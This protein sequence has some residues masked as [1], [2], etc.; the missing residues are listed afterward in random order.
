MEAVHTIYGNLNGIVSLETGA[1]GQWVK[2]CQL[3]QP[4]RLTT[5]YGTWI[6]AYTQAT[7]RN[8]YGKSL[9]F[10]PSGTLKA[11]SLEEKTRIRT[12]Y[13][14]FEAE[15]ITFHEN[16]A[17]KKLFP[18]NGKLSGFWEESSEKTLSRP[19]HLSTSVG[20]VNNHVISLG[21]YSS[22]AFRNV[23]LWPGESLY[24]HTPH[25]KVLTRI[26]FNVYP[27]GK[28]KSLE[29]A[30]P[31]AVP[32]PIGDIYAYDVTAVGIHADTNS[33]NY[34]ELGHVRSLKTST[35]AID[36][37]DPEG[38]GFF[39]M[40][41]LVISPMNPERTETKPLE[42]EF[43]PEGIRI[44]QRADYFF[45]YDQYAFRIKPFTHIYSTGCDDC[46]SCGAS[47]TCHA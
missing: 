16:E 14:T 44:N 47:D 39:F 2:E 28:L 1:N 36:I 3:G 27:E 12:A 45:S 35:D 42:I 30:N 41:E 20:E 43:L 21:F 24:V 6:P 18:L 38:H 40:P 9:S 11:I 17:I 29:P 22:G 33:L 31:T 26:G 13:G 32:T 15:L 34:D 5:Q 19:I 37:R 23:T 7:T 46:S 4:N 25:G 8:K 10:Y